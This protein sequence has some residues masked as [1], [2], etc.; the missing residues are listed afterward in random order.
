MGREFTPDVIEE[1]CHLHNTC[2]VCTGGE[3]GEFETL[4]VDAPFFKRS[5]VIDESETFYK[6]H[7]GALKITKAHL[8]EK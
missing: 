4:V 8:E 7:D 3:G 5:L 6:L 2:Y 1:L